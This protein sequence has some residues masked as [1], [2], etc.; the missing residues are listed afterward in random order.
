MGWQPSAVMNMQPS[1]LARDWAAATT[2]L[3]RSLWDDPSTKVMLLDPD[4]T[5]AQLNQP[6]ADS[7]GFAI[8]ELRGKC[9]LHYLPA[10]GRNVFLQRFQNVLA[11]RQ[12]QQLESSYDPCF[13]ETV[14]RPC[15]D[16]Q[17]EVCAVALI[18]RDSAERHHWQESLM[19]QEHR[20][21]LAIENS[22]GGMWEWDF[23]AAKGWRTPEF[24]R[25]FG[26]PDI[27]GPWSE[28]DFLR[29]VVEADRARVR[30]SLNE[31]Q[32]QKKNWTLE[33]RI[34]RPDG[35][36]RWIWASCALI[37]TE[38]GFPWRRILTVM[39]ITERKRL[40]ELFRL[41]AELVAN[42]EEGVV[43]VR[44]DDGV[45][46]FTNPKFDAMLG[47]SSAELAGRHVAAINAPDSRTPEQIAGDIIE[48]LRRQGRW[49]GEIANLRK[50][51]TPLWCR[52]TVSQFNHQLHGWVWVAVHRDIT[53]Q[54]AAETALKE[55]ENR[56]QTIFRSNPIPTGISRLDNHQFIDVN[57]AFLA[58]YGYARE[59]IVGHTSEEL[60]LWVDRAERQAMLRNLQREGVV[61]GVET[62]YRTRTG[63]IGFCLISA[64]FLKIGGVD[65]LLGT[66]LDYTERKQLAETLHLQ[67]EILRY[68]SEG[69][70]LLRT[71]DAT[72]VFTNPRY[73]QILGY[74]ENELLGRH[75]SVVND[76]AG[77]DP[78]E[79][80][81]KIVAH[82]QVH[83]TWEGEVANR[84]QDGVTIWN[85]ISVSTFNHPQY[86]EVWVSVVKEITEMKRVQ[87]EATRQAGLIAALA[88]SIPDII[89]YK[90]TQGVY[91]GCN[92][93]LAHALS[94]SKADIIGKTD[95][96]LFP[97]NAAD[98]YRADDLRALASTTPIHLEED[99]AYP[100]G[101]PGVVETL[102]TR[103][104]GPAGQV[105]GILGI[106]RDITERRR[107]EAQLRQSQKMEAVGHLAGG[108]AHEFNNLLAAIMMNLSLLKKDP[109]PPASQECIAEV[110]E[111]SHRAAELIHHL[112]AFSRQSIL[113]RQSLDW[114]D[115][116]AG[117]CGLLARFLGERI[118]LEFA[119]PGSLPKVMADKSCLEQ[120]LL[121]L[122]LNARDAMA[123]GGCLRIALTE[124]LV[125]A[126]NA[127]APSPL[128]A[129]RYVCL[130]VAD[131]GCGMDDATQKRVFEP[132]FSTKDVGKGTGLGLA[133][134]KGIMEQHHGWVEFESAQGKGSTF[135]V[136]LPACETSAPLET[137]GQAGAVAA[138]VGAIL[139]VEDD[140]AVRKATAMLFEQSGYEVLAAASS[141]EALNLWQTHQ[142]RIGLVFSDVVMPGQFSG[143]QLAQRLQADKPSL[144]VVLTSGYAAEMMDSIPLKSMV[145]L[146]KPCPPD[147]LLAA[148]NT[149]LRQ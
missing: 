43:M 7:L 68:M 11:T 17:G 72:F 106:A 93:R 15:L 146:P 91:L 82:L 133:M 36:L 131:S 41:Q 70:N 138:E 137:R 59:E 108:M 112:L 86:G 114:P 25:V 46:V 105:Y 148:V 64:A 100:D 79:V 145:F 54:K 34:C 95:Y 77:G 144:K 140:A 45:I 19:R 49:E 120:V 24:A 62:Q 126:D 124:H 75:V 121:N 134:V 39:D 1:S 4:G 81:E 35:E 13:C 143:V 18:A 67:G 104:V 50:D 130:T 98:G 99:L 90:N 16:G 26:Y 44:I 109:L 80:V 74:A 22:P 30:Q 23:I 135:R 40:E 53:R 60:G 96:D 31:G 9:L 57:D 113:R 29:H 56:F 37:F 76:P 73:N 47:Y 118:R 132:F 88:D 27:M 66:I 110:R 128:P 12:P 61:R 117:Q 129:G 8:G 94:R 69:V 127:A 84:R 14:L 28:L 32:E 141:E 125:A 3:G 89:F 115:V 65:H 122:C 78:R 136:Y 33:C 147:T 142:R 103:F 87:E 139:L 51:G 119:R 2:A 116:V 85:Q 97:K 58:M 149:F 123:E 102:K 48:V 71:S 6:M 92:S 55:S 10:E 38:L 83:G 20:L 21:Q 101:R 52:A 63:K 5:I 111:L 42:M 107:S